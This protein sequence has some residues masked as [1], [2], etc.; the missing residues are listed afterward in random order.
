VPDEAREAAA[1]VRE[2]GLA[3]LGR[4]LFNANEFLFIP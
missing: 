1:F 2:Y 4:A 3:A